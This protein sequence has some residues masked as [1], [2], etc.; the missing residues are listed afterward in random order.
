MFKVILSV[1]IAILI[2][3]GLVLSFYFQPEITATALIVALFIGGG[4]WSFICK[5]QAIPMFLWTEEKVGEDASSDPPRPIIMTVIVILGLVEIRNIPENFVWVIRNAFRANSNDSDNATGYLALYDGWKIIWL[6]KFRW[7]NVRMVDLRPINIDIGKKEVNT[8]TNP[9]KIDAQLTIRVKRPIPYAINIKEKL[10]TIVDQIISG[11]LNYATAGKNDTDLVDLEPSQ[12]DDLA[13]QVTQRLNEGRAGSKIPDLKI[14][15]LETEV[16]IQNIY[17][18]QGVL[19]AMAK[20]TEARLGFEAA[21]DRANALEKLRKGA[22]MPDESQWNILL[23]LADAVSNLMVGGK[24]GVKFPSFTANLG[25]ITNSGGGSG[26]EEK[27]EKE[28][29]EKEKPPSKPK[30]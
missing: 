1:V 27:T 12:L 29:G 28:G 3:E 26:K 5:K 6:P 10:A 11:V 25:E 20:K 22:G 9:V 13:A 17:P 4:A 8:K 24:A 30:K 23:P 14:Y 19:D 7:V 18:L 2:V 16:R 15:G 21:T